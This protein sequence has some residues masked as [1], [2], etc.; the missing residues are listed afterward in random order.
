MV[1]ICLYDL[2][3]KR[4]SFD[5]PGGKGSYCFNHKTVDMIN[6]RSKRCIFVDCDSISPVFDMPGGKGSYCA[7]HKSDEMINVKNKHCLHEG[8]S[9]RPNFDEPGGKGLYCFHHKTTTMVDIIH[10]VCLHEGCSKRPNFDEPGGKALYCFNHKTESMIDVIHRICLHEGCYKRPNF[11]EPGGKGLYCFNH[12]LINMIDVMNKR[13]MYK[14]CDAISPIFDEPGGKGSY[15]KKHKT[16]TMINVRSS[17]CTHEGCSKRPNFDKPGGKGLYCFNHK[18]TNMIDVKHKKCIKCMSR[19]YYGMPGNPTSHCAKHRESGMIRRPNGKCKTSDCKQFALYGQNWIPQRCEIH[20]CMDDKN[21]VER[22]CISC[23]LIMILDLTDNCEYCNPNTFQSAR[24]AKQNTLFSYIDQQKDL[25][26]P[27]STD[28]IIDNGN[29]GKE[30]PDRVYDLGDKIII[31]ECDEHQHRDRGCLCEQ[32]RMVNI[33]QAFGGVPVYFLRWNPDD[34]SPENEKKEPEP[35]K[36]RHKLVG[37]LIRDIKN[38]KYNLPK[39]L[40]SALYLY[41]DSW[42]SL[43]EEQ[44]HILT[45]YDI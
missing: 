31:L 41:Y 34:Y 19:S 18:L 1:V 8:C 23:K 24:L 5:K 33:G 14:D 38:N 40:V 15:C 6:V 9:K 4:A 2:C 7:K 29:C 32:T 16:D 42:S 11:D 45:K 20:K 39:A 25:P 37:D 12:K 26:N 13:C 36:K 44:W 43:V 17:S 3:K 22:E 21:L 28:T 30:R 27:Q 10:R 35:L